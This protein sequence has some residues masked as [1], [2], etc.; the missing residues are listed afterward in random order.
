MNATPAQDFSRLLTAQRA[1][2]DDFL[3]RPH[4]VRAILGVSKSTLYRMIE[5]G[6]LPPPQ[7]ISLRC[8]G[9]RRSVIEKKLGAA[10]ENA[11]D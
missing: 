9:W 3:L 7:T 2:F 8:V 5:R 6:E 1:G 11:R 10:Y 4:E